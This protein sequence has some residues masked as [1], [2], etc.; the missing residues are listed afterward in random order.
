MTVAARIHMS[1]TVSQVIGLNDGR[2]TEDRCVAAVVCYVM[3]A[4][5]QA[6][7]FERQNLANLWGFQ[8]LR[9][10]GQW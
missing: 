7:A 10:R 8:E 9:G 1:L 4:I 5:L 2:G 3:T 6:L